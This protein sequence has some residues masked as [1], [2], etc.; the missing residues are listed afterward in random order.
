MV[1]FLGGGGAGSVS[2]I[3][4]LLDVDTSTVAPQ[5]GDILKWNGSQWVPDA[6]AGSGIEE[7][8]TDGKFYVRQNGAWV[9]LQVALQNITTADT[10][11]DGADFTQQVTTAQNSIIYDGGDFTSGACVATDNTFLD[12]EVFSGAFDDTIIDGGTATN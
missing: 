7:A 1:S 4:D 8:P 5:M 2:V 12:G 10:N 9:D 11:V 3:D 6:T